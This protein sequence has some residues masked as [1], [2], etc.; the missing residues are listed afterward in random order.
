M[1][2]NTQPYEINTTCIPDNH[3]TCRTPHS[4]HEGRLLVDTAFD[5]HTS[6]HTML[7]IITKQGCK[8]I[9]VKVDPGTEVN[10]IPLSKYKKK[11]FPA[12]F[13]VRQPQK[14]SI[15]SNNTCL[16]SM[17]QQPTKVF[18]IPHHRHTPQDPSRYPSG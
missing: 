2:L 17:W 10:T 5:G 6:F 13:T 12:H 8:S 7:Q 16:Y 15:M 1:Q 18:R 4:S 9:P 14:E 11:L 3:T